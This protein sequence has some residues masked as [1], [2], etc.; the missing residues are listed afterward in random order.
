MYVLLFRAPHAGASTLGII[1]T[2][3]A[4]G[5]MS[6]GIL[7]INAYAMLCAFNPRGLG[8]DVEKKSRGE[9][10]EIFYKDVFY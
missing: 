5:F 3:L 8:E 1:N 9:Q 10:R 7:E 2:G 6:F 4:L